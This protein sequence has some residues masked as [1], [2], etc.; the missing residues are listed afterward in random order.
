M[1]VLGC[2]GLFVWGCKRLFVLG[3]GWGVSLS[4]IVGVCLCLLGGTTALSNIMTKLSPK[5]RVNFS[6]PLLR[7][8]GTKET[9]ICVT[10]VHTLVRCTARGKQTCCYS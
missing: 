10:A 1:V 8:I 3:V 7:D 2:K 5:S 4:L 6:S 9:D